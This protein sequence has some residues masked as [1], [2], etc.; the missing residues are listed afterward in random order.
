[1]STTTQEVKRREK[2]T[3][4]RLKAMSHP[5]RARA[6]RLLVERGVLSPAELA[7]ALG[8]ELSDVSYH[9]RKLEELECA[10][11]VST[12]PNRGAVEHFYRATE[13]HLIDTDE[14]ED[15]DPMMAE[16]LVCEFMQKILD[17]F[18]AS[19]KA[20]IVGSDKHFHITRTPLIL[21]EEGFQEGMEAFERCRLEMAEIEARSAER[22]S[23]NGAHAV[24]VSSG[25][26][27]F[28]VP[29]KSLGK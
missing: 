21:D 5:L 16:D 22:R 27:Y 3:R 28:K 20:D 11:L 23:A 8:A 29:R 7:R 26:A 12:R 25:L 9:V 24:P 17:D 14:W 19:R 4:N 13:R 6:L 18:V 2:T 10:E 15:L 1:M